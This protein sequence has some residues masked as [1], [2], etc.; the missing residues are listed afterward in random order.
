VRSPISHPTGQ[1]KGRRRSAL[2][3]LRRDPGELP[4]EN[5]ASRVS[6]YVYG[7][8][9]V[10]AALIA[11]QPE[12][13]RGSTGVL[14]V[15]G[16]GVSTYVAHTVGEAVGLRVREGRSLDTTALRHEVRDALPIVTAA[17]APAALLVLAWAD[18]LDASV[19]L[20]LALALVD[21][22]LAL[23]GSVV[24]WVSGERSSTR[25]FLAGFALAIVGAVVAG[26]KWQLTH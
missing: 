6:A 9:L 19:A 14:Y 13:L 7:N 2:G 17:G 24:A 1:V 16:V 23:L 3:R 8:V 5:V 26:L 4:R 21:L 15:L 22:R 25:V 12:E 18:L 20:V 10:L 11:L